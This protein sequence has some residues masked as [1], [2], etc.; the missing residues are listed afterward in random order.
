M[1]LDTGPLVTGINGLFA[2]WAVLVWR[3][4]GR[5]GTSGACR[6]CLALLVGARLADWTPTAIDLDPPVGLW[7]WGLSAAFSFAFLHVL[8]DLGNLIATA[9]GANGVR[10]YRPETPKR[11]A[12]AEASRLVRLGRRA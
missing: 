4:L 12:P 7:R 3:D 8:Q 10:K 6:V 9:R 2:G 1:A 5:R 11:E